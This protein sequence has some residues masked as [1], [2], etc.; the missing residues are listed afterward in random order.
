M[1]MMMKS[2]AEKNLILT[3][4]R[5]VVMNWEIHIILLGKTLIIIIVNNEIDW[6]LKTNMNFG[7][8]RRVLTEID[9]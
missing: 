7:I 3:N 5:S 6:L 1:N 9:F 4:L 8:V 2:K